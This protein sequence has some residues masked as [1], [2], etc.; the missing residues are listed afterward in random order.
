MFTETES[1]RLKAH[2][3]GWSGWS[4]HPVDALLW[5]PEGGIAGK[6]SHLPNFP[7]VG[8]NANSVSIASILSTRTLQ[9]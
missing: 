7:V 9:C 4:F 3:F 8:G 1:L 5:P 2:Q 6:P